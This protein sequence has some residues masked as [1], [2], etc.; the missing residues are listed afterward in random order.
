MSHI[1]VNKMLRAIALLL[2]GIFSF[3]P[4]VFAEDSKAKNAK[5][6]DRKFY[7][8]AMM[9]RGYFQKSKLEASPSA[10]KYKNKS[11]VNSSDF[12]A[13]YYFNDE[14]RGEVLFHQE[15]N[16]KF[17]QQLSSRTSKTDRTFKN[18]LYALTVGVSMNVVDFDYGNLFLNGNVGMSRVKEKYNVITSSVGNPDAT[19][20]TNGKNQNNFAYGL[21]VGADFT[22]GS[23]LH[24]EIAYRFSDYGQT[25]SLK[26]VRSGEVGKLK[27]RSHNA[28]VGL[29][30]DM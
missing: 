30:V 23:R 4:S 19:F 28:L 27:L 9:D 21:G 11:L 10:R 20:A 18:D 22:F 7:L 25:K 26:N 1:K 12:G 8:K 6:E 15:Y 16:N 5:M 14:F 13:G 24:A 2:I 29:R 3:S 17:T